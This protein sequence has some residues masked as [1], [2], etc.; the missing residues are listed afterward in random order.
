L[1]LKRG[2]I[3]SVICH[4]NWLQSCRH[5]SAPPVLQSEAGMLR[6]WIRAASA[7]VGIHLPF[8][9]VICV[10]GTQSVSLDGEGRADIKFRK[11]LVF[12]E[13]PA[14][15]D[16]RDVYALSA[17]KA[18][19]AVIYVSPDAREISR[20]NREPGREA[21][22]W[23]PREPI[24]LNALYEHQH[25]WR[26]STAF[27]D[28]A[29]CIEYDCNMKTGIF[30][31]EVES[32]GAFDAAVLFERPRWPLRFDERRM[33]RTALEQLNVPGTRPEI[34]KDG[35][36]VIAEVQAPRLGARYL[37]VA[38]RRC[39]VADCEQWLVHTSWLYRWQRTVSAWAHAITG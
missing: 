29:V 10:H 26:P 22:C 17:S 30:T 11:L 23:L 24:V 34:T 28:P 1:V 20:E 15:G 12:L 14:A 7:R 5:D 32:A 9:G 27:A 16:L 6:R 25:G 31:I 21:I 19:S 18:A 38:F 8:T 36:G 37:L 2:E 4:L 35:T 3:R 33:I 39:G 13:E